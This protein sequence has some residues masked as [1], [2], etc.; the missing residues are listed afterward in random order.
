MHLACY[1]SFIRLYIPKN[2]RTL[3]KN[4]KQYILLLILL[5]V[6]VFSKTE[7]DRN[8]LKRT[9]MTDLTITEQKLKVEIGKYIN[10]VH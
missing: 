6:M 7:I 3:K 2:M 4:F 1:T 5:Y 10:G 9:I 8:Q